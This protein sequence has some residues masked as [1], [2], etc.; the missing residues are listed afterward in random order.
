LRLA[1]FGGSF[2]PP[3]NGHLA[4]A[5]AALATGAWDRVVFVPTA[6]SPLKSAAAGAGPDDRLAMLA[7]AAA[8]DPRLAIDDCEI[9][10]GGVSYTYDTVVDLVRRYR[11]D[12]KPGLL[13]G[14]DLVGRFAEWYRADEL[15]ALVRLVV[16]RRR[17]DGPAFDRPHFDLD[18]RRVDVSSS[19][20]RAAAAAGGAWR[21]LVPDGVRRIVEERGLYGC[22]AAGDPLVRRLEAAARAELSVDRYL[23][24]RS[25]ALAAAD[26]C[27]RFGLDPRD[28]LLAGWAHDLCKETPADELAKL[29]QEDGFGLTALER[30]R[31]KLLHGRA[32]AV[33]VRRRFGLD[34]PALLE[35]VRRHT[36]GAR[37]LGGLAKVVYIADKIDPRRG[38]G[39]DRLRA[40]A[41][42]SALDPL[43]AAVLVDTVAWL[44]R[45][46]KDVEPAAVE[47]AAALAEETELC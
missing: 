47:L 44:R 32:A 33:V 43:F 35:A 4:L 23:H 45:R 29:A 6:R 25:V 40:L 15:A 11:C 2:D 36:S 30:A 27:R 39:S 12:G 34:D 3:H 19:E 10:R 17:P 22:A 13:I 46:G 18:N 8:D 7:A 1:I 37:G 14:D 20:I 41:A 42:E 31:P 24:S 5:D 38:D 16:A 26:L 9:V 28:G 21:Y